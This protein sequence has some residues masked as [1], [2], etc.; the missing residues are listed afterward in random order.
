MHVPHAGRALRGGA[1][2][3]FDHDGSRGGAFGFEHQVAHFD[4]A[5]GAGLADLKDGGWVGLGGEG[6]AGG[7]D[8]GPDFA[9]DFDV[10]GDFDCLGDE[11]GAVV[12]VDDLA[13][14]CFVQDCLDS[15]SVVRDAIPLGS[16]GLD[17]EEG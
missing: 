16:C 9:R 8:Q 14:G 15:C 6:G 12:E 1:E 7:H 4:G 11:V 17:A 3:P 2:V 5:R 10:V 13:A